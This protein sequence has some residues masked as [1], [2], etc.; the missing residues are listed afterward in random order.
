MANPVQPAEGL[1]FVGRGVPLLRRA[2]SLDFHDGG[3]FIVAAVVVFTRIGGQCK[4]EDG[5]GHI[6]NGKPGTGLA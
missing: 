2:P 1:P 4:L 3:C 6:A 5:A